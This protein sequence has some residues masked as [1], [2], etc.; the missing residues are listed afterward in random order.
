MISLTVLAEVECISKRP[1]A[2]F[3]AVGLHAEEV[4]LPLRYVFGQSLCTNV[5][6]FLRPRRQKRVRGMRMCLSL[7]QRPMST[8]P[9]IGGNAEVIVGRLVED[10]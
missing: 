6:I 5:C 3:V 2:I 10:T 1:L 8:P 7:T 4:Q 9:S